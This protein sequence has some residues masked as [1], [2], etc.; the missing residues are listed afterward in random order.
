MLYC[1]DDSDYDDQASRSRNAVSILVQ[2]LITKLSQPS[3][4]CK[5][6]ITT[7]IVNIHQLSDTVVV[8]VGVGLLTS[9]SHEHLDGCTA[10]CTV[11]VICMRFC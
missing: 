8:Y 1:T 10:C 4:H 2:R 11:H 6:Y 7:H 9:D 3:K 5:L